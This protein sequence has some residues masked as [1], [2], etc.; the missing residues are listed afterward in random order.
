MHPEGGAFGSDSLALDIQ[1]SRDHGLQGYVKYL[2]LCKGQEITSWHDLKSVI[3]TK[4]SIEKAQSLKSINFFLLTNF[5]R[6]L[7]SYGKFISQLTTL[8]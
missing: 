2:S 7:T 8:T 3:E 4:V 6:K 5:D 1:R